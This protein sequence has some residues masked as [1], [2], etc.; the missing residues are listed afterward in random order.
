M[1][2]AKVCLSAESLSA[3][4]G[5]ICRV[6]RLMAKVLAEEAAAG[7]LRANALV[8]SD[9][10]RPADAMLP[11]RIMRGSRG[12]FFVANQAAAVN[13]TH[14]IYD[15]LGLTRAHNWLP[16]MR[17]P[18]MTFLHGIEIWEVARADHIR[19]ARRSSMLLSNTGYTRDRAHRTHGGFDHAKVCWLA[20]ENDEPAPSVLKSG[21]PTLLILGRID[22]RRYKGHDALIDCWP[23]VVES[24][25]DARL[26]IVG[27]GPG[28]EAVRQKASATRCGDS[29]ELRGFVPEA[30]MDAVWAESTAFAM[31]SLGE[32]FGLV[33]IEAM[34]QGVPVIASIHD[35]A[36]E[37]NIDGETGYNVNLQNPC[38]LPERIIHVLRHQSVA[39][40]LGQRGRA[41]W[42]DHFR[43]SAFRDRFLPYLNEFLE[44]SKV[45]EPA[46]GV[47]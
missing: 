3:G 23:Q 32:G 5:G 25:T 21:R 38:E 45:G 35:A 44:L 31:P 20:T 15:F 13:H 17:R 26:L 42:R 27:R 9:R 41:R 10:E 29:I 8:L 6:A 37:I 33:Y 46:L 12:A 2:D 47:G 39:E 24:V 1:S 16:P 22:Q 11:T 40:S 19:W 30:E 4:N 7:R 34:R 18:F 28:L 43:Y 36:P 14:F